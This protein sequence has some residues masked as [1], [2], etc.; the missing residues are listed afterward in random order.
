MQL[1]CR[2]EKGL[3]KAIGGNKLDDK[4]LQ[5]KKESCMKSKQNHRGIDRS[6]KYFQ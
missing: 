5:W 6:N 3:G 1:G 4:I 2:T